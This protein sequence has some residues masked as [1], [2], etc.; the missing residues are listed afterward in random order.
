MPL[1]FSVGR[2]LLLQPAADQLAENLLRMFGVPAEEAH[3]S[4]RLPLPDVGTD[5]SGSVA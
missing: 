2:P 5:R 1:L 4:A 3:K